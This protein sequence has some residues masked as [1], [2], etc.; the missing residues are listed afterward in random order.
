MSKT[1]RQMGFRRLQKSVF[2]G[3]IKENK[4]HLLDTKLSLLIDVAFD[5]LC[6]VPIS[7]SNVEKINNIGEKSS[8]KWLTAP[9]PSSQFL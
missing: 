5:A 3:K 7:Q 4:A 9:V 2:V 8:T 6:I 1:L